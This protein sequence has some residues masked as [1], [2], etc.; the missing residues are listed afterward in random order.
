MVTSQTTQRVLKAAFA[1]LVFLLL[2]SFS[3]ARAA[4]TAHVI[5]GHA[6]TAADFPATFQA[7]HGQSRCTG[8]FLSAHVL[9]TAA[10][11]L[12][13]DGATVSVTAG[14]QTRQGTCSIDPD[15]WQDQ[16]N[17]YA[18]CYFDSAVRLPFYERLLT[19]AAK[20][21]GGAKLLV[22]GTGCTSADGTGA[23]PLRCGEATLSATAGG[24]SND[25]T[26]EGGAAYCYGDTGGP[27]FLETADQGPLILGINRTGNL[28]DSTT[29]AST[30]KVTSWIR[31]WASESGAKICGLDAAATGCRTYTPT[32]PDPPNPGGG[33]TVPLPGHSPDCRTE[34]AYLIDAEE[35]INA[36]TTAMK[37]C[38]GQ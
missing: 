11:C 14:G 13:A 27:T 2:S 10:R 23:G 37:A 15:Y 7:V 16:T 29:V 5:G 17:D 18:L 36:A 25:L 33:G 9:L 21:K 31:S 20:A 24:D 6:V 1:V 19:D 38:I 32:P 34:L 35:R 8:T 28:Q 3:K 30:L 12:G 22:C 26:A 4:T